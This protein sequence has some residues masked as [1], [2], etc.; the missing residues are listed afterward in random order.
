MSNA[1]R[2][3]MLDDPEQLYAAIVAALGRGQLDGLAGASRRL[4]EIDPDQ[5]RAA[6][7][8]GIVHLYIGQPRHAVDILTAAVRR[9][10]ESGAALTNLAKAY[11]SLEQR[12]QAL[13]TLRR[14][15]HVDPNQS[16]G[17]MWYAKLGHVRAGIEGML[18]ALKEI[19]AEPG[20][21]RANLWLARKPLEDGKRSEALDLYRKALALGYDSDALLMIS[22]DLGKHKLPADALALVGPRYDPGVHSIHVGINLLQ[23]LLDLRRPAEGKE[24]LVRM[25]QRPQEMGEQ[26]NWYDREFARLESSVG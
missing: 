15:L 14:S 23:S 7:T 4:V 3:N 11:D 6:V 16:A 12:E 8:E 21:W 24:L 5:Q 17:L 26:L 9:F 1:I 22:G 2:Q 10:G 18:T 19:A 20:S 25:R 13:K